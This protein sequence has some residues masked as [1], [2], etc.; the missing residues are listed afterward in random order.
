MIGHQAVTIHGQIET[1]RCL[2][3]KVKKHPP[4]II[5]EENILAVIAPLSNVMGT[6]F[7]NNSGTSRHDDKI[8]GYSINVNKNKRK[9]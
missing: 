5:Y 3:Q 8:T 9:K 4:V 1:F 7:D 6:S 2:S